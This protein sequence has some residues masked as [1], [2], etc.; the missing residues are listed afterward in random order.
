MEQ[1][2]LTSFP[3][4][5]TNIVVYSESYLSVVINVADVT[6]IFG[7]ITS[8]PPAYAALSSLPIALQGWQK[9]F[10]QWK[11]SGIVS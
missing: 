8:A 11:E 6:T 3:N 5:G 2:L 10:D 9:V 4:D 7:S 1:W